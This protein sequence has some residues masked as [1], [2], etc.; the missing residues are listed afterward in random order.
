[1][2][3]REREI[4][5]QEADSRY[6]ELKRQLNARS[7][8]DEEFDAQLQQLTVQDDEGRLWAKSRETG[9]WHYRDGRAWT[10]ATP[11]GYQPLRTPPAQST[12]DPQSHLEQDE[13]LT[14]PQTTFPGSAATQAQERGKQPREVLYGIILTAAIL[15]AVGIMVWR[16]IPN[17]P[18]EGGPLPEEAS[19]PAPG[20]TLLEHDSEALWMEVP[21]EWD[22]TIIGDSEGEKGRE[23]WSAFLGEGESAGP[24]MTAVND[25]YSWRNGTVGHQGIYVVASKSLAQKYTDDELI[26]LGPN[27]YSAACQ[28]GTPQD[29]DR[30][31]YSGKILEWKNC[32]GDSDHS[33]IT[34]A[35]APK[36]RE[37]VIVAQIGGYFKTQ[38]DEEN[39]QHVLD[40]LNADCS[41]IG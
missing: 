1:M 5:F 12:P 18:D 4:D 19:G 7:I 27:N 23:A 2:D 6:V 33:A 37:C 15:M 31:P 29:F 14:S 3:F 39:R 13:R 28:A 41:K 17:A 21:A 40:T 36:D 8:S 11:P 25:L 22:E 9:E 24:S 38:S 26:T 34:L 30:P 16:L 20:Y 32:G 35:A 10:R